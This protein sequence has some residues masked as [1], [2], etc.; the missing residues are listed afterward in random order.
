MEKSMKLS[1]RR[2]M[3]DFQN[4]HFRK[5]IIIHVL[6]KLRNTPLT[7]EQIL[8]C[9]LNCDPALLLNILKYLMEIDKV[10]Y[11]KDQDG[12]ARYKLNSSPFFNKSEL[13]SSKKSIPA[14]FI[15]HK[16]SN[17]FTND[18]RQR[19]KDI[20]N[21]LPEAAPVYY[22]W[23]FSESTYE[24]LIKLILLLC[25]PHSS[26]AFIGSCTLGALFSHCSEKNISIFDIDKILLDSISF[27]Y[28]RRTQY[29]H[30]DVSDE[31]NKSLEQ[32]FQFVFADPPWSSCLLKNFLIRGSQLTSIGGIFVISFPQMF[33]RPSAGS[34]RNEL[35]NLA[36]NLGLSLKLALPS[37]AE[38][39][40]PL[41]E[42]VAYKSCGI[43]LDKPWRKGD[44]FVFTKTRNS[45]VDIIPL[46][47]KTPQW[48]QYQY[49]KRRLFLKKGRI[50]DEIRTDLKSM[51]GFESLTHNSTSSR[52]VSW[53][54][55]TIVS[56]YNRVAVVHGR[57][58]LSV[59]LK[60]A[61]AKY[62]SNH[63]SPTWLLDSFPNHIINS[64][65][66]ML[67]IFDLERSMV[68]K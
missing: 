48:S 26:L 28:S 19:L 11:F 65:A 47:N 64:I 57:R 62:Q 56:T 17:K 6:N 53:K 67:N 22:Q 43:Y 40:V 46:I 21:S 51:P 4:K 29:F 58:E 61:S 49:G 30:Y 55:A 24:N 15:E 37:Y 2:L 16:L 44:L 12:Y 68:K 52:L 50:S 20:L 41:F 3:K 18:L 38:Y 36:N 5:K 63:K 42:Q 31:P 27:H 7:F 1:A 54:K 14:H 60:N 35:L 34:E 9:S 32:S 66:S 39:S 23:W 33:T 45:T 59:L 10:S 13:S 25:K 8:K